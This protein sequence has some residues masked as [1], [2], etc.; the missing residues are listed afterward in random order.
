MSKK[1]FIVVLC[2]IFISCIKNKST[3]KVTGGTYVGDSPLFGGVVAITPYNDSSE[4]LGNCTASIVSH[5]TLL[6]AAHCVVFEAEGKIVLAKQVEVMFVI[7]D[8]KFTAKTAKSS[9]IFYNEYYNLLNGETKANDVALVVFDD[10]TFSELTPISLYPDAIELGSTVALVGYGCET[11][12]KEVFENGVSKKTVQCADVGPGEKRIL[13]KRAGVNKVTSGG[14]LYDMVQ[15]SQEKFKAD[16]EI[17]KP[18]GLDVAANRGDSGGPLLNFPNGGFHSPEDLFLIGVA[19]YIWINKAD[20]LISCYADPLSKLNFKFI[21][22]VVSNYGAKIPGIN[23]YVGM[24]E[25]NGK[26][27]V[28][29]KQR[30]NIYNE[31]MPDTPF[32]I[33]RIQSGSQYCQSTGSMSGIKSCWDSLT[34]LEKTKLTWQ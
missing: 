31:K 18:T 30:K 24:I 27:R 8:D 7:F 34:L 12:T 32:T 9:K 25:L 6:T 23:M 4:V 14:C 29:E 11:V 21:S 13:N 10:N 1:I 5:N 20:E 17:D 2:V 33:N 28:V 19:S 26:V 16:S 22:E 3:T 15:V